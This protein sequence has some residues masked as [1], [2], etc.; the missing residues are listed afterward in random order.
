MTGGH[1][2]F[3]KTVPDLQG[4]E[5]KGQGGLESAAAARERRYRGG[6]A[7]RLGGLANSGGQ[8]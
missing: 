5:Q 8:M 3:H 7:L 2:Y 6:P 1:E 4:M